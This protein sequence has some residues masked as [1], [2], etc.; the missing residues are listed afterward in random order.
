M[1]RRRPPLLS[2]VVSTSSRLSPSASD[3]FGAKCQAEAA[4]APFLFF[5]FLVAKWDAERGAPQQTA[6]R[7]FTQNDL[8]APL[9][10]DD[11][12]PVVAV[13]AVSET[14]NANGEQVTPLNGLRNV[15]SY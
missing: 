10:Q 12:F 5:P 7:S 14:A 13:V 6:N 4:A 3:L 1:R 8:L 11:A 2:F 15:A 9:R